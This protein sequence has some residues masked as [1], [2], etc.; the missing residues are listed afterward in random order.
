MIILT[1]TAID[2]RI[3]LVACVPRVET[4]QFLAIVIKLSAG[5]NTQVTSFERTL[6]AFSGI[7][8]V[9]LVTKPIAMHKNIVSTDVNVIEKASNILAPDKIKVSFHK[10]IFYHFMQIKSIKSLIFVSVLNK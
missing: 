3:M 10:Y 9:F 6:P 7:I 5:Q 4:V 8:S 2:A 1:T